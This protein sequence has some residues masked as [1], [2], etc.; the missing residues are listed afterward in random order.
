MNT[1]QG[2]NEEERLT[3]H[4]KNIERKSEGGRK[5]GENRAV[6]KRGLLYE[7]GCREERMGTGKI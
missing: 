7:R 2:E 3:R 4:M 5:G 6:V 1:K